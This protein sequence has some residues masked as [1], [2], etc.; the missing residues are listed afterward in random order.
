M[1]D[2]VKQ[3]VNPLFSSVCPWSRRSLSWHDVGRRFRIMSDG[4]PVATSARARRTRSA[5][6]GAASKPAQSS[7]DDFLGGGGLI[8][9]VPPSEP[10]KGMPEAGGWVS[11]KSGVENYEGP[12]P[13]NNLR[14]V[15]SEAK[16][17]AARIDDI[18]EK[19]A[20]FRV[21]M[22]E[23]RAAARRAANGDE[24]K[25]PPGPVEQVTTPAGNK[26]SPYEPGPR[27]AVVAPMRPNEI[28]A[29]IAS[30]NSNKPDLHPAYGRIVRTMFAF[31]ADKIFDELNEKRRFG[32]PIKDMGYLE[33]AESLDDAARMH[34]NASLL[35]ADAQVKRAQF[36]AD[37]EAI[38]GDMRSQ[39]SNALKR[40]KDEKGGKQITNGDVEARMASM[41][42]DEYRR[43]NVLKAKIKATVGQL[44][45][46]VK[47]WEL[48]RRE[49]DTMLR[50]CRK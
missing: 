6:A 11:D 38:A 5:A 28:D 32:K 22:G 49:I 23:F 26:V 15:Q 19:G 9:S 14:T 33:L 10:A 29:A 1:R 4:F 50:E 46:D 21:N 31:D 24:F 42:P 39:A 48:R 8:A 3:L 2:G 37:C 44:E 18:P 7:M 27:Q 34:R 13:S 12:P 43:Q 35:F 25:M 40:E 47:W 17:N 16:S 20:S 36:E 45:D 30:S 41:F